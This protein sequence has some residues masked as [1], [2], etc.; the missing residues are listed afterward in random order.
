VKCVA[1]ARQSRHQKASHRRHDT[2][3]TDGL[4]SRF[5]GKSPVTLIALSMSPHDHSLYW[6]RERRRRT[7]R[8][9]RTAGLLYLTSVWTIFSRRQ[10]SLLPVSTPTSH[11]LWNATCLRRRH[12]LLVSICTAQ[13]HAVFTDR[14]NRLGPKKL[15]CCSLSSTTYLR[16]VLKTE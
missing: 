13:R 4:F 10:L 7:V 15:I 1:A 6:R 9:R 5:G 8:W 12:P 14:R 3:Q 16:S 11:V 2:L